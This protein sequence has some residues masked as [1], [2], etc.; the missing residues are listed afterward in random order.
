MH[1]SNIQMR[2]PYVFSDED[3]KVYYLYGSTDKDIWK[4]KGVGFEAYTSRDLINWVGPLSI[5]TP[6][7]DFWGTHNFWAPEVHLHNNTYYLF[8]SFKAEGHVRA[9][10]ILASDS[11]LGPFVPLSMNPATP[12]DWEC[13]DGTLYVDEEQNPWIVFCHEWVQVN[14]GEV[15]ALRLSKDLSQSIGEAQVLFRASEAQWPRLIPRRD[16][17]GLVDARVTDGPFLHTNEDGSLQ[18]LWSS[19]APNGYAMGYATSKSGSILGPWTQHQE[20]LV[21]VDGGH[22]MIFKTF[23]GRLMLTYHSPNKTPNERAFFLPLE[24]SDGGLV[25]R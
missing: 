25:C 10:H 7:P 13:L 3:S 5:F 23:E 14:D 9:T 1:I 21:N 20:P 16:G 8:A 15:C 12:P 11:P 19:L 6:S 18:L 24:E 4:A 17:T 2:D 22:G